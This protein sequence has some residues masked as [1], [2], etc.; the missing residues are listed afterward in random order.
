MPIELAVPPSRALTAAERQRRHRARKR[1]QAKAFD[2]TAAAKLLPEN[3]RLTHQVAW[4]KQELAK[5]QEAAHAAA[6]A[7]AQARQDL[8]STRQRFAALRTRLRTLLP[9]L[10][11]ATEQVIRHALKEAGFIQWLDTG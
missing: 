2:M 6:Q 10:S 11:P 7:T 3:Q 4:L 5:Q 1:D 8:D 9:R